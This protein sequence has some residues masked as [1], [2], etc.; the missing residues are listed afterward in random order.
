MLEQ[1]YTSSKTVTAVA[2][3]TYYRMCYVKTWDAMMLHY[4]L[5]PMKAHK[6]FRDGTVATMITG[7]AVFGVAGPGGRAAL[8]D[9]PYST[10]K[11]RMVRRR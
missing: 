8:L 5:A 10:G 2:D 3:K 9:G 1:I 7:D 11:R 6:L 4:S